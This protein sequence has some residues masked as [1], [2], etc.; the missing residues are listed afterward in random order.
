M[1]WASL[2]E[3]V[4]RECEFYEFFVKFWKITNFTKFI[5]GVLKFVKNRDFP[6]FHCFECKLYFYLRT[7]FIYDKSLLFFCCCTFNFELQVT[8]SNIPF[9]LEATPTNELK[10]FGR[11]REFLLILKLQVTNSRSMDETPNYFLSAQLYGI[12]PALGPPV[13]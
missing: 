9:Y 11:I 1:P 8:Q 5:N 10:K 7:A 13:T 3:T 12:N 2:D 6:I 4:D